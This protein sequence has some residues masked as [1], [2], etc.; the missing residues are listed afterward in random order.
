MDDAV[1]ALE[2][3]GAPCAIVPFS[4]GAEQPF[5]QI[6]EW[7]DGTFPP[8]MGDAVERKTSTLSRTYVPAGPGDPDEHQRGNLAVAWMIGR[9]PDEHHEGWTVL[10]SR[11]GRD[12][13]FSFA[14]FVHRTMASPPA[15]VEAEARQLQVEQSLDGDGHGRRG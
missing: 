6:T 12:G 4:P 8:P 2:V 3:I 1:V 10:L 9:Y 14:T 5:T 11:Q 15:S 7:D 13:R